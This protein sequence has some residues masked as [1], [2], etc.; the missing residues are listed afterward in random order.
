MQLKRHSLLEKECSK[1]GKVLP[2]SSFYK[3]KSGCPRGYCKECSG[4]ISRSWFK[5]HPKP[6]KPPRDKSGDKNPNWKGGK[7]NKPC[8]FCGKEMF[9]NRSDI[10][11]G[12]RKY[13]SKKCKNE[14]QKNKIGPLAGN[15][16]GGKVEKECCI[17]GKHYFLIPALAKVSRF[18]SRSCHNKWKSQNERGAN[19]RAW[20]GGVT[21][22]RQSHQKSEEWKK[23][24]HLVWKRD[25]QVCQKCGAGRKSKKQF[26]I[27][28]LIS[29]KIKELRSDINNLILL[30]NDCHRFVHSRK[31][32]NKEFLKRCA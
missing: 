4:Q 8:S 1:C 24:V 11:K 12:L 18:C 28:H 16:R 10:E 19:N 32:I 27:H 22:E 17:C 25:Q 30:C 23:V 5:N 7:I 20:L 29:F 14:A 31:N 15:W 6:K 26:H 3:R 13:C 9:V 21:A 2:I